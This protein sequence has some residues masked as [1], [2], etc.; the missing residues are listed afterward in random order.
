[1]DDAF[2][3]YNRDLCEVHKFLIY[4]LRLIGKDRIQEFVCKGIHTLNLR[5]DGSRQ[6]NYV[7]IMQEVHTD[8]LKNGM[9]AIS[10]LYDNAGQLLAPQ[11]YALHSKSSSRTLQLACLKTRHQ[12]QYQQHFLY[13]HLNE[14]ASR[15]LHEV[16]ES[17][18]R[19]LSDHPRPAELNSNST[20]KSIPTSEPVEDELRVEKLKKDIEKK[21]ATLL[22]KGFLLRGEQNTGN[23]E[24]LRDELQWIFSCCDFASSTILINKLCVVCDVLGSIASLTSALVLTSVDKHLADSHCSLLRGLL[25]AF[26]IFLGKVFEAVSSTEMLGRMKI[27]ISKLLLQLFPHCSAIDLIFSTKVNYVVDY[28]AM[29]IKLNWITSDTILK[30]VVVAARDKSGAFY[31]QCQGL[32]NL[33]LQTAIFFFYARVLVIMG[34][35]DLEITRDNYHL[36][37][38]NEIFHQGVRQHFGESHSDL[39]RSIATTVNG[40]VTAMGNDA[41]ST[42]W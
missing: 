4:Y 3:N 18:L 26:N 25:N 22:S 36:L 34:K 14:Y 28:L 30:I 17:K 39:L 41:N 35:S 29:F 2:W 24:I 33:N 23:G 9:L 27:E 31:R 32:Q 5:L 7:A 40:S 19:K 38:H 16:Q 10:K 37:T 11:L 21:L 20:N 8:V 1:M 13:L 12:L 6:G 42:R 15:K